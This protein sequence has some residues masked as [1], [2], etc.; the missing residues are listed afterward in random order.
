[1]EIKRKGVEWPSQETEIK[2]VVIKKDGVQSAGG[3]DS[4]GE[5]TIS[6]WGTWIRRLATASSVPT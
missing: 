2:H 1:M 3:K 4:R 5:A 6:V